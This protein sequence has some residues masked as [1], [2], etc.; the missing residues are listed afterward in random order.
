MRFSCTWVRSTSKIPLAII[1]ETAAGSTGLTSVG[2]VA[3][4]RKSKKTDT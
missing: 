2:A 4:V 3:G 1:S